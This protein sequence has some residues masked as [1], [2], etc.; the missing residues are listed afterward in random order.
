MALSRSRSLLALGVVAFAGCGGGST[1]PKPPVVATHP[2]GTIATSLVLSGRPHGVTIA[3]SGAFC[4]SQIDANSIACGTLTMTSATL[5]PI[6]AVGATPAHVALD[7]SALLA[8]TANQSGN[9]ASIVDMSSDKVVASVPLGDGGFNVTASRARGYVTT[10]GG[11][12]FVIDAATRQ[13]LT[14]LPVGAAANGL[15]LDTVSGVLYVS[16]RDAGTI[17]V[18][19]TTSNTVTRTITVGSGAQRIAL[20]P[21]LKTL[22]VASEANGAQI[23]DIASGSV[24]SIPGVGTGAVGLALSPDGARLYVANPPAG[25]VQIVDPVAKQVLTTLTGLG[26]PRNVA[27][28]MNGAVALVT[29]ELGSVIVIR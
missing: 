27:F 10:A 2:E 8:Y 20:S 22:Y 21:D 13:A 29:N 26:R 23:V 14:H 28:G 4:V 17:T 9:T 16:S 3:P 12:L 24:T 18:I 6:I 15:A 19:N 1:G 5:G 11:Q 25:F 7:P